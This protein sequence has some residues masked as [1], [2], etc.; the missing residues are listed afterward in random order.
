MT[1]PQSVVVM[2]DLPPHHY[3]ED[4]ALAVALLD[5][6]G[7]PVQVPG[8]TGE[9]QTLRISQLAKAEEPVFPGHSVPRALVP[10]HVQMVINFAGGLSLVPAQLYTWQVEIDGDAKPSWQ[11]SFFVA[12]PSPGPVIG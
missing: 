8:P 5:Q 11:A 7:E 3:N 1:A 4:F 12:G 10:S 9:P 2:V 6:S